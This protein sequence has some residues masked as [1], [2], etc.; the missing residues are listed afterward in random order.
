[1]E[2]NTRELE[3]N[4]DVKYIGHYEESD[5][6]M[7]IETVQDV[8]PYLEK[9]KLELKNGI[10]NKDEPKRKVASIPL[11]LVEKWLREEGLDIFNADHQKRLMRKLHDPDYAYLRTLKGRYL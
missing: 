2:K 6:R 8:T 1:M 5:D 9:N 7:I 11:V 4:G 3:S 10:I